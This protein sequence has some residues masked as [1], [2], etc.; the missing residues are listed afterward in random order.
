VAAIATLLS[1]KT[2]AEA[3]AKAGVGERTLRTW[4]KKA[5]F[6]AAYR[7][8]RQQ[9]LGEV[10]GRV[11]NAATAA[12]ET[13]QELL[14]FLRSSRGDEALDAFPESP[15]PSANGEAQGLGSGEAVGLLR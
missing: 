13:L 11:L 6:T 3:A 10:V 8:A 14:S 12:V 9:V 7:A 1:E 2:V 4:L 15:A 5:E